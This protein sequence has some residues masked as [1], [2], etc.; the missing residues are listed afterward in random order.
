MNFSQRRR[1]RFKQEIIEFHYQNKRNNSARG[2]KGREQQKK[3][4][5]KTPPLPGLL[6]I[7]VVLLYHLP[8]KNISVVLL[9]CIWVYSLQKA[10]KYE[11]GKQKHKPVNHHN[12][13]RSFDFV[14]FQKNP[15]LSLSLPVKELATM[16]R[17][18]PRPYEFVRKAWH[19]DRHQPIRGSL[20][21]EIFRSTPPLRISLYLPVSM[22]MSNP[23]SAY[24]CVHRVVNE[25]HSAATK[26][27]KE[28]QEKLPIVVLKAE[29]IM[30]S[31]ANSEV[32]IYI[33]KVHAF[34]LKWNCVLFI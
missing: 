20:I 10:Q 31:K 11:K 28:W 2:R 15:S 4:K 22:D 16:P 12:F 29:E 7:S 13:S 9:Y 5:A 17:P 21:Q 30:Y 6:N 14:L 1:E 26:K 19:S 32:L 27:N 8:K 23:C 34:N 18:G 33:F 24:V 25:V 3:E